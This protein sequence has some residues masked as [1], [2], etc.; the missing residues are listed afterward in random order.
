[1]VGM[2]IE[3]AFTEVENAI[4]DLQDSLTLLK[5]VIGREQPELFQNQE[6]SQ[7]QL[8]KILDSTNIRF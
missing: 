8:Q 1:M 6:I 7:R 4:T 5:V 2:T 3:E